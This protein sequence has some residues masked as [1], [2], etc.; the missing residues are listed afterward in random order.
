MEANELVADDVRGRSPKVDRSP[1]RRC[2]LRRGQEQKFGDVFKNVHTAS[3]QFGQNP[4]V[5]GLA[6]SNS[7]AEQRD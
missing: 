7:L 3:T 4:R 6:K 5:S 1:K 2:R